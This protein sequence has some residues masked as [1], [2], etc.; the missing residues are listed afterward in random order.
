VDNSLQEIAGS[1]TFA[2]MNK[3]VFSISGALTMVAAVLIPIQSSAQTLC[4]DGVCEVLFDMTSS[5]VDFAVPQGVITIDFEIA[6]GS[7]G[8]GGG[9]G[10]VTGTITNP[11]E[12]LVIVVGGAGSTGSAA[13]GGYNGGGAA[14][15]YRGN[16]GS[17]GG[18]SD[19]RL[20]Q[21]LGSRIVVA[22]GGGGV[23]GFSG[24]PGGAGG[25]LIAQKGQSGQGGGGGGGTQL[26]GG[27]VGPINGGSPGSAGYFGL[28][29]FGGSASNAGGG[30]GGGGWYG[31][32]GGG[33]DTDNC[34]SD[35][36]GGGGGSS[37]TDSTY[38]SNVVH[39]QGARQGD[40]YVILRY[41][42]PSQIE[43][44]TAIQLTKDLAELSLT[45]N[46]EILGLTKDDF[47]LVGEGCQIL[48][49]EVNL[50][51]AK[52]YLSG[53]TAATISVTLLPNTLDGL[54]SWPVTES[55]VQLELDLLAPEILLT[56]YENAFVLAEFSAGYIFAE[57]NLALDTQMFEVQGCDGFLIN[58][59]LS[60]FEFSGCQDGEIS[61]TV[62]ANSL[63]DPMGNQGPALPQT[64]TY[65]LDTI[66]PIA[67][68]TPQEIIGD[69]PFT[70]STILTFGEEVSFDPEQVV[71]TS[72][73]DCQ[74]GS[75]PVATGWLFRAICGYGNITWSLEPSVFADVHGNVGD[76]EPVTISILNP[77]PEIIQP[78]VVPSPEQPPV[79]SGPNDSVPGQ[80]PITLP[81][82]EPGSSEV[83]TT[84]PEPTVPEPTEPEPVVI[85]PTEPESATEID[86][87]EDPIVPT[88]KVETALPDSIHE[89]DSAEISAEPTPVASRT[90]EPIAQIQSIQEI[91]QPISGPE[92]VL[93]KAQSPWWYLAGLLLLVIAFGFGIWRFSE[94]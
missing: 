25:G 82:A 57:E 74:F 4:P 83:G 23:G 71:V 85:A 1:F 65:F 6:A 31:G 47:S 75:E 16:E 12:N 52:V 87:L 10:L 13:V 60:L 91:S 53:C 35:G 38:V 37:Y 36:G 44:F 88:L 11:P 32:G 29:G 5:Q 63:T 33:S 2:G 20:D 40:G 26:S 80:N 51:S 17:G 79:V 7:G 54:V 77:E 66:G 78:P 70:Y 50:S 21:S 28:G 27:A 24:A 30:G 58:E 18:A 3:K 86:A 76:G 68:W 46:A 22:G 34:C 56:S 59:L 42:P 92:I 14:G 8:S 19:I 9:G 48:D 73:V 90:Q 45:A 67:N 81:P 72:D 43:S 62:L 55:I 15:G 39:N 93:G 49:P 61:L 69:G 84:E 94:R 89:E 41:T 64:Q